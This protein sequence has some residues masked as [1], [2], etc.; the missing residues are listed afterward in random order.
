MV[1]GFLDCVVG[2]IVVVV[3]GGC[4]NSY[5]VPGGAADF[6][7]LGLTPEAKA[8]ATDRSVQKILD[9][10]P[11]VVF[12]SAI[13][14]A[15]VQAADYQSASYHP[16]YGGRAEG[17]YSV[18]TVRDVEK[19]EDFQ[20]LGSLPQVSGVATM[21][22]IVLDRTL[23]TDE[24]LRAAAARLHAGL[25]LYYTFDTSFDVDT[26]VR[27]LGVIT[28]GLFP[29]KKAKVTS[30][31]SAV[32]MDVNN[33]YVYAVVEATSSDD[34]LTNAWESERTMDDVRKRTEREAFVQL[35]KQFKAEWPVVVA[36]YDRRAKGV[37]KGE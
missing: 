10:K 3:V 28:L 18:V 4:A 22:R 9:K 19:D 17:A 30:T 2:L 12:P 35:L 31:A 8:A 32:L 34:Q 11:L 20:A 27:P 33:G 14:V 16:R 29:N 21:K 37:T 13:A 15:R 36:T 24:E 23:N 25:L 5:T 1:R 6:S 7:R 26:R